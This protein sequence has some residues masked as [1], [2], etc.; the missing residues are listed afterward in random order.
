MVRIDLPFDEAFPTNTVSVVKV[1]RSQT[2]AE[3]EVLRLNTLN[4]DKHCLYF[5]CTAV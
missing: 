1:V 2:D 5:Y 3:Q 4:A